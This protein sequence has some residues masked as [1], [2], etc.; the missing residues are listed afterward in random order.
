MMLLMSIYLL[1]T[2]CFHLFPVCYEELGMESGDIQDE[3]I[4][5]SSWE[6]DG[7]PYDASINTLDAN[8]KWSA[9]GIIYELWIQADI[10]YH[11]YVSGVLTQ[12]EGGDW[13]TSY[14]VSTFIEN[15]ETFVKNEYG[16]DVTF[17]FCKYD[18]YKGV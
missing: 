1:K 17:N 5:A 9:N 15:V 12:G 16:R 2:N 4:E 6:L 3:N 13:I 14:T 10:Q 8:R 7:Q 18:V 11:T